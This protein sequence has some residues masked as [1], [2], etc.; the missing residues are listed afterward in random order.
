MNTFP[1]PAFR[2][3]RPL[4]VIIAP[5]P[6]DDI[7]GCG[8]LID[9]ARRAGWRLLVVALTDG[10]A[11]HPNSARWPAAA[12][13]RLRRGEMRRGLARLGAGRVPLRFMGWRDGAL[14]V[15]G[16]AL[17]LRQLL[18]AVGATNVVA[19]S[20][21]DHH[22]DHRAAWQLA[23]IAT[24]ARWCRLHAYE[25]WARSETPQRPHFAAGKAA[26]RWAMA[27]HRSQV[28][29]YIA[30]DPEGFVFAAPILRRLIESGETLRLGRTKVVRSRN[31]DPRSRSSR[32]ACREPHP[33]RRAPAL[34]R[35]P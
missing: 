17:R 22:P 7:L 32:A 6:D 10:Q 33:D 27:A 21:V 14:A 31:T 25:V 28:T 2:Q 3:R 30:D 26:K 13:G 34:R 20:P 8:L 35:S 23:R 19:A 4:L 15:D 12:L 11:S 16:S 18:H 5:H 9:A 1:R 29:G 24:S